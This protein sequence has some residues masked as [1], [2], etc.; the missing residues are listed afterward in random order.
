MDDENRDM[1]RAGIENRV[2]G[3]LDEAKGR[4]RDAVG[5]ATGDSTAQLEGKAEELKGRAQQEIGKA[6]QDAVNQG[7]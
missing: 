7:H 3:T 2:E 4:A 6:Q 5:G 1:Q